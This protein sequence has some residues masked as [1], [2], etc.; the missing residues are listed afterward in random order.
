MTVTDISSDSITRCSYTTLPLLARR[1]R[2]WTQQEQVRLADLGHQP[3][4]NE[5]QPQA[6]AL[7]DDRSEHKLRSSKVLTLETPLKAG[8]GTRIQG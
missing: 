1:T 3:S 5:P 7:Q 4:M 2:D 8:D 6:R